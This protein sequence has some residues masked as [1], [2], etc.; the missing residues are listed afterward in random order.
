MLGLVLASSEGQYFPW[1]N[2]LSV[3]PLWWGATI[4]NNLDGGMKK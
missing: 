1:L 4:L 2:F 3:L